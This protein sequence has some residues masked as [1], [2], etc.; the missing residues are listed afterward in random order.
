[1]FTIDQIYKLTENMKMFLDVQHATYR[2]FVR[3]Q[4]WEEE[5]VNSTF[6]SSKSIKMSEENVAEAGDFKWC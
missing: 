6:Q 1:M 4:R 3:P 2:C 5:N